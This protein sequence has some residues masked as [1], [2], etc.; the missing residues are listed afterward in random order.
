MLLPVDNQTTGVRKPR[1]FFVTWELYFSNTGRLIHFII[2]RE[3]GSKAD[4]I[5]IWA[6]ECNFS[7]RNR[8]MDVAW[9]PENML[10]AHAGTVSIAGKGSKRSDRIL[11]LQMCSSSRFLDGWILTSMMEDLLPRYIKYLGRPC[12]Q[13]TILDRKRDYGFVG[14]VGTLLKQQFPLTNRVTDCPPFVKS[15]GRLI[16][17]LI[18]TRDVSTFMS[19]NCAFSSLPMVP[20]MRVRKVSPGRQVINRVFVMSRVNVL[21][22]D[23]IQPVEFFHNMTQFHSLGFEETAAGRYVVKDSSHKDPIRDYRQSLP[24][25]IAEP[26]MVIRFPISVFF[27]AGAQTYVG[28]WGDGSQGFS[29]NPKVWTCW[30][31]SAPDLGSCMTF[32]KPA[33]HLPDSYRTVVGYLHECC[34]SVSQHYINPVRSRIDGI[35][36]QFLEWRKSRW[37]TS[38]AAIWLAICGES[39]DHW[40]ILNK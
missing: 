26:A 6:G 2:R 20:T 13:A 9:H 33:W 34:S 14:K 11:P 25:V 12:L 40:N 30:R 10:G 7:V 24:V 37:M 1:Y 8:N 15:Q 22:D 23:T 18:R 28:N 16:Y 31:S 29:R 39:V 32:K 27:P 35:F 17:P 21:P 36:H 19:S 4:R 3:K 5:L 38:P